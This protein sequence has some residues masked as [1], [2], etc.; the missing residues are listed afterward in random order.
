MDTLKCP[1]CG[2][3]GR[4]T[5]NCGKGR[6][7]RKLYYVYVRCDLCGSQGKIYSSETDPAEHDWNTEACALATSAWNM[8]YREGDQAT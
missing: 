1:H 8:R 2:G 6:N 4:L 7:G 3:E 5:R